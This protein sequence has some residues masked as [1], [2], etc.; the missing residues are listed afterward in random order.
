MIDW[1]DNYAEEF[2]ETHNEI[3]ESQQVATAMLSEVEEFESSMKVN[4]RHN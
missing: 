1:F 3:G 2:F 4:T